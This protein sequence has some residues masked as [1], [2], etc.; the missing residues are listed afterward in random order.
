MHPPTRTTTGTATGPTGEQFEIADDSGN[1]HVFH[2]AMDITL[3]AGDLRDLQRDARRVVVDY[4]D[5]TPSGH[6][7]HRVFAAPPRA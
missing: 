1:R 7:A 2:V 5:E 4:D 3:E 6:V